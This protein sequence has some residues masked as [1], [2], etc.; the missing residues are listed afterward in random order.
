M[1]QK[2]EFSKVI[3][4]LV[5]ACQFF[6]VGFGA[7]IVKSY[8]EML[9]EYLTF[10]GAPVAVAIAFYSWKAKAENVIKLDKRQIE[11]LDKVQ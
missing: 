2:K 7:Y 5:M 6:G 3:L 11:K 1:K 9:G 4:A 8:P 10:I